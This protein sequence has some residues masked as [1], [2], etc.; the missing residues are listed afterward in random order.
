VLC[1]VLCCLSMVL[2][3]QCADPSSKVPAEFLKDSLFEI[4]ISGHII[5]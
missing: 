2:T 1:I 4:N 3:L 5:Y